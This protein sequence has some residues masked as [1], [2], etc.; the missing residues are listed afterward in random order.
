M[1]QIKEYLIFNQDNRKFLEEQNKNSLLIIYL[2][3]MPRHDD[4]KEQRQP[5]TK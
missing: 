5:Y 4:M 2:K 3:S 1:D